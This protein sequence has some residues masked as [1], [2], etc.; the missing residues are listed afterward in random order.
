M[1]FDTDKDKSGV[2]SR[3]EFLAFAALPEV[4]AHLQ[5][6]EEHHCSGK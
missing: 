4:H 5:Q 6:V 1:W 2:L 3:E